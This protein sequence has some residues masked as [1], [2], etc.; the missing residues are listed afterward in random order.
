MIWVRMLLRALRSRPGTSSP[1]EKSDAAPGVLVG[2]RSLFVSAEA[3]PVRWECQIA[4][5]LS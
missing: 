5:E 2:L 1:A 4:W 3:G